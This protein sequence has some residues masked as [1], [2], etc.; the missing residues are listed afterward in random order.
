MMG[1]AIAIVHK[2]TVPAPA[3]PE[4]N[5]IA[6]TDGAAKSACQGR[7]YETILV[8][9]IVNNKALSTMTCIVLEEDILPIRTGPTAFSDCQI[10]YA[11]NTAKKL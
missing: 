10:R 8:L 4:Q 7:R 9:P 5:E 6:V 1:L 3:K 2:K 11:I